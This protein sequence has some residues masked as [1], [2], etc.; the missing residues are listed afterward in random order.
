MV[1]AAGN[2]KRRFYL[3]LLAMICAAAVIRLGF[4][5]WPQ[6]QAIGASKTSVPAAHQIELP[7][8]FLEQKAPNP[9]ISGR[10][11]CVYVSLD[12][13]AWTPHVGECGMSSQLFSGPVD[14]FE[15]DLRYGSFVLRQT[16]LF[17]NDEFPV[18]FTRTYN[19]SDWFYGQHTRAF[20]NNANHTYDIAPAGTRNP[21]TWQGIAL[22]DAN[23]VFFD[24]I[25]KGTN[26]SD[27]VFR[28]SETSSV[29][30]K[31]I[32]W[33]NGDGWTTR[34]ADGTRIFFPESYNAKKIADGAP[35]E[36]IDPAG[37]KLVLHRDVNRNLQ[38]IHTPHDHT[39][40]LSYN[41]RG[42]IRRA[43]DDS[44]HWAI[45]FYNSDGMLVSAM[46]SSGR[47]RRYEY[48]GNKLM[49][50]HNEEGALLLQN[51]YDNGVVVAQEFAG[52]DVYRYGYDWSIR[53]NYAETA[54]VRLP[55]DTVK[56]IPTSNFVPNLVKGIPPQ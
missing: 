36:I 19:S 32:T 37:H 4:V 5:L 42:Q 46:H 56:E 54:Y 27:A 21:Y 8:T 35:F 38:E 53:G 48:D 41:E 2:S 18:P 26:Y 11:P 39:I 40:T 7:A 34:L 17:L 28:H 55:D 12:Q 3:L 31:A 6:S 50:I 25:S 10:Y 22:E 30:Y 44:G 23:F 1:P 43:E 45:Y 33:W 9:R 52:G 29:F 49:A 24:R 51:T 47:E 14:R 20:G 13:D 15:V 16:E